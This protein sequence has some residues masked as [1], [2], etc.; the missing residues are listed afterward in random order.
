MVPLEMDAQSADPVSLAS[1]A[2]KFEPDSWA[3]VNRL[4]EPSL[5]KSFASPSPHPGAAAALAFD[6]LVGLL[7][8]A[9]ALAILALLLFLD[10]RTLV[11]GHC[12]LRAMIL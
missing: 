5:S 9:L 3:L 10:V 2:G 4:G 12:Y 7:Q 1:P 8:K 11:V 6:D